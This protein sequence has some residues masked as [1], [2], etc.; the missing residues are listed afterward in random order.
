M[1][2]FAVSLTSLVLV[3]SALVPAAS[4][5]ETLTAFRG[6]GTARALDLSLPLLR[7]LPLLGGL[8]SESVS[9]LGAVPAVNQLLKGLTVGLTSG[10]FASQPTASG[11][12]IGLCGLLP[13]GVGLPP[14]PLP[15]LPMLP[16]LPVDIPCTKSSVETSSAPDGN[17]GDGMDSCSEQLQIA[18]VN[19]TTSCANS[20][21]RIESGMPVTLNK[22]GIA[23]LNLQLANLPELLGL[24]VTATKD[25]LIDQVSTVLGSVL[26]TVQGLAPV[27]PVDLKGAVE[28][29]LAQV[30]ALD[31]TRLATIQAG[32]TSTNA[33]TQGNGTSV[34]AEAAGGKVGLLGITNPLT[35]G[36]V[37]IDV[38]A[39]KAVASWDNVTGQASSS[40]TP[41][42]ATVQVRDLLN[43]VPGD[44]LTAAIPALDLNN[45]L[46]PL[47]GTPL[48]SSV[49]L[50]SA[51][52]A[53]NGQNV[54]A[55]TSGVML[56]LLKGF[57]ESAPGARDGGIVLRFAAA[58]A[59]VT[60]EVV[61]AVVAAPLPHTGGPTTAFM[62][63]ALLLGIGGT[64]LALLRRRLA[65]NQI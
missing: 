11:A 29:L 4:A 54:V 50:A 22:G 51:T 2:R 18:L 60:G 64:T 20:A 62:L 35:D 40:A 47:A 10:V 9:P 7:S 26:G 42:V 23:L 48:A 6:A 44:Y 49:E 38:S 52:P 33:T 37:I 30:K 56:R 8:S 25:A 12:A 58:D 46:A 27:A 5:T 59:T 34:V 57:G 63:G 21:S 31:L 15:P 61:N 55:S 32:T 28:S 36:L 13:D 39:A 24:N 14:L 19:L 17:P 65:R 3:A 53:Q 41:A 16:S 43:L 45:I 1:R